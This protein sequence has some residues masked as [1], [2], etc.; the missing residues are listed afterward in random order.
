MANS[1]E[2]LLNLSTSYK[3][4]YD[5]IADPN[6]PSELVDAATTSLSEEA[7]SGVFEP[8]RKVEE[9]LLPPKTASVTNE[10][11]KATANA[12]AFYAVNP[13]HCRM[14]MIDPDPISAGKIMHGTPASEIKRQII[15]VLIQR[16]GPGG[17]NCSAAISLLENFSS[18][19]A[20]NGYSGELFPLNHLALNAYAEFKFNQSGLEAVGK[21][22][23]IMP[24]VWQAVRHHCKW[25]GWEVTGSLSPLSQLISMRNGGSKGKNATIPMRSW[26]EWEKSANHPT[27]SPYRFFS[28]QMFIMVISSLRVVEFWRSVID[29]TFMSRADKSIDM[30][31]CLCSKT[32]NGIANSR[33]TIPKMGVVTQASWFAKHILDVRKFGF[34]PNVVDAKGHTLSFTSDNL[35]KGLLSTSPLT[36]PRF[37]TLVTKMI[38]LT[39]ITPAYCKE[40]HITPHGVHELFDCISTALLWDPRARTEMGRWVYSIDSEGRRSQAKE[41]AIMFARYATETS[42]VM[43]VRLRSNIMTAVREFICESNTN[44][45]DMSFDTML[46]VLVN[47][48]HLERSRFYGPSGHIAE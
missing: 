26:L 19:L 35:R 37:R 31:A 18:F 36:Y 45:N 29:D 21:G 23:S 42:S 6:A 15:K 8:V 30:L 13:I 12:N 22:T 17:R 39:G 3:S 7:L 4:R 25:F 28:R 2:P 16:G 48:S 32:K 10:S 40:H 27:D 14:R 41:C 46:S 33:W 20:E 44:V 9:L 43:Q 5:I 34:T 1:P 47:S 38:C 11:Q 24:A